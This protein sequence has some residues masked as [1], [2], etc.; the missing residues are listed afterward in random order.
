M[1]I[2]NLIDLILGIIIVIILV[3]LIFKGKRGM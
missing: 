3:K 2:W 1:G